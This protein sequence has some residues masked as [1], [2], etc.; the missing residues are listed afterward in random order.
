MANETIGKAVAARVT[1]PRAR[2]ETTS[3]K[4]AYCNCFTARLNPEEAVLNF[5]FDERGGSQSKEARKIQVLHKVV[6]SPATARRLRDTL[7]AL[8]QKHDAPRV[9]VSTQV[10]PPQKTG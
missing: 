1:Q 8:F 4:S 6:L 10:S 5:G 9:R 3:M 2:V 7:V